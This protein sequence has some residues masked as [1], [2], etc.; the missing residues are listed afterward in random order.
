MS[1]KET[2]FKRWLCSKWEDSGGWVERYEPRRGT[3]VGIAD[4]QLLV[5]LPLSGF[6]SN[7][8]A[9]LIP[10]EL[11]IAE[12][13]N[14]ILYSD[15]IRPSQIGWHTRLNKFGHKSFFIWGVMGAKV[16]AM[17]IGDVRATKG[18]KDG[19]D[20]GHLYAILPVIGCMDVLRKYIAT[21]QEDTMNIDEKIAKW[22]I[23]ATLSDD[24]HAHVVSNEILNELERTRALLEECLPFAEHNCHW[25]LVA[26]ISDAI[27]GK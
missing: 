22:R 26:K 20:V 23:E 19:I 4:I 11:K 14:G 10:V 3:G 5:S 25:D 15:D 21:H 16:E 18:W 17:Y 8:I 6:T 1:R 13:K 7:N 24:V 9:Q 2:D 12:V 27:Q